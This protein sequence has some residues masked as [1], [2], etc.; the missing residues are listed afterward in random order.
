MMVLTIPVKDDELEKKLYDMYQHLKSED[1]STTWTDLIRVII[2]E[3]EMNL[4]KDAIVE[5]KP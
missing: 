1:R 3:S 2:R 5:G 4:I